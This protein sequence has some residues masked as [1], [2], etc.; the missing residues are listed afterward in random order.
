M[1]GFV[2][3][4]AI[5]AELGGRYALARFETDTAAAYLDR[6]RSCYRQW[7]AATKVSQID[8]LLA[9]VPLRERPAA[10]VDQLDLLTAVKAFQAGIARENAILRA[11]LTGAN[12]ILDAIFDRLPVGLI[13]LN[14]DLTVRRASPRAIEL[15]GLPIQPGTPHADLFDRLTLV[16]PQSPPQSPPYWFEPVASGDQEPI[17]RE[18]VVVHQAVR[19]RLNTSAIA[20]RDEDGSLLGVTVLVAEAG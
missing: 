14:P 10:P 7:G 5:A 9:A 18:V 13:L 2:H 11:R 12:Q 20:L 15:I 4:E 1:H 3:G 8:Q 19:R 6:A 17:H 16:D